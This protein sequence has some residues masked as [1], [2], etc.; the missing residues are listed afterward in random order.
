MGG[1]LSVI[2]SRLA[3]EREESLLELRNPLMG[4]IVLPYLGAAAARRR[5]NSPTPISTGKGSE[6]LW[7]SDPFKDVGMRLHI[8]DQ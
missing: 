3:Q 2:H 7:S 5:L 1:V 6:A 4:M 8:Q